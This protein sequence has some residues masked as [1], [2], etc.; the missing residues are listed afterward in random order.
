MRRSCMEGKMRTLVLTCCFGILF[1]GCATTRGPATGQPGVQKALNETGHLDIRPVLPSADAELNGAILA[2]IQAG[3]QMTIDKYTAA[4]LN[5][6]VQI[7]EQCLRDSRPFGKARIVITCPD[8]GGGSRYHYSQVEKVCD[9]FL[10][11]LEAKYR[12]DSRR[13]LQAQGMP[14]PPACESREKCLV[15]NSATYPL[16]DSQ[17]EALVTYW[18]GRKPP[19]YSCGSPWQVK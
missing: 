5:G 12:I 7:P 4:F 16:D 1:F 15:C 10:C 18:L 13:I 9:Y 14:L 2:A 8:E 6:E 11:L 19:A 3:D 17:R